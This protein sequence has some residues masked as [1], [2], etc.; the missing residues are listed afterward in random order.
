MK[1]DGIKNKTNMMD[2]RFD[3]SIKNTETDKETYKAIFVVQGH[4]DKEKDMLVHNLNRIRH[5]SVRILVA[6]AATFKL[7]IWTQ[8]VNQAYLQT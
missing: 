1:K 4:R 6:I 8:D 5:R 2:G 3:L 7:R